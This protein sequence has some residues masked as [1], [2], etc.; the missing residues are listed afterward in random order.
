MWFDI[1]EV[2]ISGKWLCIIENIRRISFNSSNLVKYL[3]AKVVAGLLPVHLAVCDVEEVLDAHLVSRRN[4]QKR[5]SSGN[6]LV[7]SHPVG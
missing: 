2:S 4:L 6:V 7:L 5:H 3:D 1:T